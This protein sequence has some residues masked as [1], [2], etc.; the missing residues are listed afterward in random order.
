VPPDSAVAITAD[1][2]VAAVVPPGPSAYGVDVV[3]ALLW[4]DALREGANEIGIYAVDGPTAAPVLHAYTVEARA[5][6]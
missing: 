4:P 5:D 6:R 2:V 3:H 1:G